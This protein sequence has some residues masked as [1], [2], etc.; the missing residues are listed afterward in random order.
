MIDLANLG[1]LELY[2]DNCPTCVDGVTTE[3][4]GLLEGSLTGGKFSYR[5]ERGHDWTCSWANRN[6]EFEHLIWEA[7]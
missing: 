1:P 6:P 4:N 5:C 7:P 3:P 2:G